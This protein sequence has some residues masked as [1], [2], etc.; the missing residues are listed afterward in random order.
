MTRN[1]TK[2]LAIFILVI[3]CSSTESVPSE[4]NK[5]NTVVDNDKEWELILEENFDGDFSQWN[6]WE[7]GAFNNEIQLY[8]GKQLSC[9]NGILSITA[10]R[11]SVTGDTSPFDTTPKNFEYVSGRIETKKLFGPSSAN[12]EN[13]MRI[14]ARIKLPKG[15][16]MWPAFWTYGDPWPT[17]GELDILEARGNKPFEFQSNI[18]YGTVVNENI[19]LE[20]DTAKHYTLEDNLTDDF[21]VYELIWS[22][23]SLEIKIND[24]TVGNYVADN[25]N[26]IQD[27]FGNKHKI[28]F[29]LAVGGFF[30]NQND[31]SVFA[32]KAE[33]KI[34]WLKVYQ[35]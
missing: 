25:K 7:G 24:T 17:K 29:N 8:T 27:I 15:D 3:A 4:N 26:Y 14:M 18:F 9:K 13:S 2:A 1:F 6:V 33:M 34:D 23:E 11:K 31:S 35:R 19:A 30:F 22:K 5:K 28:A 20:E 12:G 21:F 16:G 32:D 10:K